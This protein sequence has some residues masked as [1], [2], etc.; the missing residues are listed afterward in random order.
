MHDLTF[1]IIGIGIAGSIL[2]LIRRDHLHSHHATWWLA[3]AVGIVTLG[4]YPKLIDWLATQLG[5]H[6]P[7]SLLFLF[8]IMMVLV[9]VLSIDIHQSQLERKIR[10][11][12][13]RL[14]ILEEE[15]QH[16]NEITPS[17]DAVEE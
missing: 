2:Y 15:Q 5:I 17:Q 8:G 10:R 14:A 4:L 6:Y 12:T 7:P 1:G 3:V 11:L 9:K 16:V 13:Q